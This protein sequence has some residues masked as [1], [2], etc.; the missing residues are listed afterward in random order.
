MNEN[1]TMIENEQEAIAADDL[2]GLLMT[3]QQHFYDE[4]IKYERWITGILDLCHTGK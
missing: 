2:I 1:E 3:A 4:L